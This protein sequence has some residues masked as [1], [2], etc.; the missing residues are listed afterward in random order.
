M[1]EVSDVRLGYVVDGEPHLAVGG[2][3]FAIPRGSTTM[4]LGPS[5][6]GKSTIL[7]AAAGF[8][9]PWSGTITVDGRAA[10]AAPG[11]D[12]A[13][14]FQEFDQLFPWRTVGG[15][16]EFPLRANGRTREQARER[17][18]H[19]LSVMGLDH[20]ATRFPHQLS[21]GMKQRVAIARALALEPDVL[22]MDEPFGALDAQTRDRLQ[23]ELK[24]VAA[25]TGI[26]VLFVTHSI[27]EA[28]YVGDQVVVLS[29]PPSDVV[30]TLDV[31]GLDDPTEAAFV[32]AQTRLRSLLA[33]DEV[34]A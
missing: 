19:W 4:L 1:L 20:A 11:P 18:G 6:C 3:S 31:R 15:N 22:L 8:L 17:A 34:A 5:G 12:R 33:G 25:D 27:S 30:E 26:T 21:G 14:V 9:Q 7:K 24:Q 23:R 10:S 16:L 2:V 32:A 29:T 28:V 13:V